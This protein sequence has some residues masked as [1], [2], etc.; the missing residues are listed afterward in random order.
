[1]SSTFWTGVLSSAQTP[2]ALRT[3]PP[4]RMNISKHT[5]QMMSFAQGV[6]QDVEAHVPNAKSFYVVF[7]AASNATMGTGKVVLQEFNVRDPAI[8]FPRYDDS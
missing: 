2:S 4:P 7:D 6:R 8:F 3:S 5:K 1:M